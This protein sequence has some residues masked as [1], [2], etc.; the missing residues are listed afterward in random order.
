MSD[1][2]TETSSAQAVMLMFTIS[3]PSAD[4]LL[5][6]NIAQASNSNILKQTRTLY[7]D[8]N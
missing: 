7:T 3:H 2:F 6:L 4:G 8:T 5:I 1:F